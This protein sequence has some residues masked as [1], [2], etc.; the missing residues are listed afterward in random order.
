VSANPATTRADDENAKALTGLLVAAALRGD[1]AGQ[2]PAAGNV[3]EA[4]Q[5]LSD[6]D[7]EALERGSRRRAA[8]LQAQPRRCA[9][10]S[11]SAVAGGA[12][13]PGTPSERRVGELSVHNPGLDT[14]PMMN[15]GESTASPYDSQPSSAA[16]HDD[17][18]DEPR[19]VRLSRAYSHLLEHGWGRREDPPVEIGRGGQGVVFRVGCRGADGFFFE[20][21]VKAF[22]PVNYPSVASYERAM[23]R[24]AG[25]S[26]LVVKAQ[27]ANVVR[28]Q[29]FR[30]WRG[31]RLMFMDLV[32][33]FDLHALVGPALF[34]RVDRDPCPVPWANLRE[35]VINKFPGDDQPR[36]MPGVAVAIVRDCLL[37]LASLHRDEIVHGDIKPANIMIMRRTGH[38]EIVDLGSAFLL[39]DPPRAIIQTPAYAAPEATEGALPTPQSDLAS[40]GYV[41]VELLTGKRLFPH[42]M[43]RTEYR[44][45]KEDLP[46]RLEHLLPSYVVRNKHLMTF[47]QRLIAPDPTQR[48]ASASE[49]DL[50]RSCG[51]AEFLHQLVLG[52]LATVYDSEIRRWLEAVSC[53]A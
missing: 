39:H 49:A 14:V 17:L 8:E 3:A 51:A 21:A 20:R 47:C 35:V 32:D 19:Q 44:K 46:P 50:D 53:A 1:A 34:A 5:D 2:A 30:S 15:A 12:S 42:G 9:V 18:A 41:L 16:W 13:S 27:H 29:A 22:S 52:K 10:R 43:S 38:A 48:F 26:A 28:V 45:V 31:V 25:V 6:A 7:E 24:T 23:R 33:G 36:L 11:R 4:V 40:L 37:G